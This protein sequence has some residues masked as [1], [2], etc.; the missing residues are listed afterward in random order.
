MEYS[1]CG[2]IL[3]DLLHEMD[4]HLGWE[5]DA[6]YKNV[7][8]PPGTWEYQEKALYL[9]ISTS[10]ARRTILKALGFSRQ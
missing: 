3:V 9:C 4:R 8:P 7:T 1:V 5:R 6:F 10:R 2:P